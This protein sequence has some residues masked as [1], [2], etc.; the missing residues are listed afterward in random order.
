MTGRSIDAAYHQIVQEHQS[1]LM[2]YNGMSGNQR[3]NP[4]F[5]IKTDDL[6]ISSV[7]EFNLLDISISGLAISAN[8]PLDKGLMI[9]ISIGS[10]LRATAT[11]VDC[12]LI[13]SADEWTDAEFRISCRYTEDLLGKEILVKT[14]KPEA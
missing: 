6:W 14:L 12:K 8:Y 13:S 4:R 11:V 7:P 9:E 10:G 3:V 1:D 5:R 2:A